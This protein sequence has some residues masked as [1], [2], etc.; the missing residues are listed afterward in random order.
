MHAV[1][2]SQLVSF[3]QTSSMVD[4]YKSDSDIGTLC[5]ITVVAP[6]YLVNVTFGEVWR[7]DV[8]VTFITLCLVKLPGSTTCL[9][10]SSDGRY[11]C[12]G[13]SQGFS[14]WC[15][16]SLDC[17]SEWLQDSVEI[18]A[19]QF[20]TLTETA[21]LLCTIDDMGESVTNGHRAVSLA[22]FVNVCAYFFQ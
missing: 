22:H 21:H 15:A 2:I 3:G 20:V 14:V 7:P 1:N 16:S 8:C 12:V 9:A 19:I 6:Q 5:L 4:P 13:H 11:L 17:V 18:T 10:C